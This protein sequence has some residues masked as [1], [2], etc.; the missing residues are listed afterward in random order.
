MSFPQK[1]S[2]S[3][4]CINIIKSLQNFDAFGSNYCML[5]NA[6]QTAISYQL[7]KGDRKSFDFST[8]NIRILVIF[9][10]LFLLFENFF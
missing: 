4:M 10:K 6:E 9:I 5:T 8:L 3:H 7:V 2:P 1:F